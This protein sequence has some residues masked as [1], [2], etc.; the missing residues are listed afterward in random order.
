MANNRSKKNSMRTLL[1]TA[2]RVKRGRSIV[3]VV[4]IGRVGLPLALVLA[5]S[6]FLVIGIDKDKDYVEKLGRGEQ[7]FREA[8]VEKLLNLKNFTPTTDIQPALRKSDILILCVGTPLTHNYTPDYSQLYSALSDIAKVSLEGKLIIIRSTVPPGTTE[9]RVIPFIEKKTGLEGGVH[10]GV[11]S[12]PERIVEGRAMEEIKQLP[13]I[14]GGINAIS[15]DIAAELFKK[16][17]PQKKILRTTPKA[18]EL[19]KLFTNVYRYVN[20]ALA[21]EF[22]LFAESFGQD[23]LEIVNI[24]NDSYPRGGIPKPGL[25]GGPCLSKDGYFLLSETPFSDFVLLASRLNEFIPQHIVNRLKKRLNDKGKSI[26]K[27]K[28]AVLGLAFKA[29]IDDT[30]YSPSIRIAELL[31]SENA[32]V[33]RHDPYIQGTETLDNAIDNA[34][35]IILATNHPEFEGICETIHLLDTYSQDCILVDC[36]GII[37]SEEAKQYGFDYLRFGKSQT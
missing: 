5:K 11:A 18:A 34:D 27:C 3:A 16:I 6:G 31:E 33:A 4:G 37:N 24:A 26:H 10:F 14:I 28:I 25:A 15:T 9:D 29:G 8:G 23:A 35:V 36:W 7:V 1:G 2:E 19:A 13:E 17:N 12:C 21:N 22:A 20:F 30:R 32:N